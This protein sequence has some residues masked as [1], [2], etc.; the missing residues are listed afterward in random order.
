M[1]TASKGAS[2]NVRNKNIVSSRFFVGEFAVS[3]MIRVGW[4]QYPLLVSTVFLRL[5][6]MSICRMTAQIFHELLHTPSHAV[7]DFA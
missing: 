3:G 1:I 2:T 4:V 6:E 7:A 5:E